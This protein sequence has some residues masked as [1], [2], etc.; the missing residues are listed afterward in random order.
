MTAQ[1]TA[2]VVPSLLAGDLSRL[3]EQLD[4]VKAAGC[5]WVSVDVMD[6]H[7]VP[8]LSFGPDFVK[9]AKSKGFFVDTH[10]M[11]TN[12]LNVAKWFSDAGS[13]IVTCHIEAVADPRKA[14]ETIR[15]LGVKAGLAV[16]PRTPVDGLVAVLDVC[17]LAL[18]MSVEPGFGGQKFMADMLPKVSALR[19]AIKAND[20]DSYVQLDGGVGPSNIALAA[21]AGADSL[22]AGSAV[23]GAKDVGAA[24]RDLEAKARSSYK[25]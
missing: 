19:A 8:N 6:G 21:A 5:T 15:A 3:G 24:F 11:V 16:K 12:P 10:L 7:F 22:V 2:V 20:Y 14:L 13:D 18:V 17:D 9:L 25:S 4:Q 23:F 1:K